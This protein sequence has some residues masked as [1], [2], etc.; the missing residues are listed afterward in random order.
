[1]PDNLN[2]QTGEFIFREGE[3][4][5]YAYVL[6]EGEVEIVKSTGDGYLTLT[7]IDKGAIF[8]EMAL[9]DG[10]PRSAGARV[11]KDAVVTEVN[12]QTFL[13][14]IQKNPTAAFNIMKRLS[15]QL[16]AANKQ[17]SVSGQKMMITHYTSVVV[18]IE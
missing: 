13:Q 8:G 10:Q 14:Y 15:E 16:R 4:A 11:S 18:Q 12:A 5:N 7:S 17:I 3:T 6:V 2:I 1:M 9:I